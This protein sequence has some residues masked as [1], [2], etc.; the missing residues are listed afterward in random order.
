VSHVNVH[1]AAARGTWYHAG[2]ANECGHLRTAYGTTLKVLTIIDHG[3]QYRGVRF[4]ALPHGRIDQR[5]ILKLLD[6]ELI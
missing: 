4:L 6:R 5:H 3:G 2:I 1:K